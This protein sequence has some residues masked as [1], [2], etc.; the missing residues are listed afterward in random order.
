MFQLTHASPAVAA[1]DRAGELIRALAR[2]AA[3]HPQDGDA[4]YRFALCGDLAEVQ[5]DEQAGRATVRV[6]VA[7]G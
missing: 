4:A 6:V 1:L 2:T 3:D 5:V 7:I